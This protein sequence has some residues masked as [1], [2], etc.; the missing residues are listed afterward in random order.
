M[1]THRNGS[2]LHRDAY[3]LEPKTNHRMGKE[4][5]IN[6]FPREEEGEG[7]GEYLLGCY[8]WRRAITLY[9]S[10]V[11]DSRN[12][13]L[14]FKEIFE[15]NATEKESNQRR[16]NGSKGLAL[17]NELA[18]IKVT[19][20]AMQ[21]KADENQAQLIGLLTK[22]ITKGEDESMYN[23]PKSKLTTNGG[24]NDNGV[25]RLEGIHW[26]NSVNW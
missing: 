22:N 4:Y 23:G 20:A 14:V 6:K 8:E 7:N 19:M 2:W 18:S 26:M 9:R 11:P 13:K 15:L 3:M 17:E 21:T 12:Y 16:G 25:K 5:G 24:H 10:C 1:Q